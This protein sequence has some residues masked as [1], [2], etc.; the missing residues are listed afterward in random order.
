MVVT[1][2]LATAAGAAY[3]VIADSFLTLWV[4][5]EYVPSDA[6]T[7]LIVVM[8]L[9]FA[10]IRND[11][12]IID[13]TLE[14]KGKVLLGLLAAAVSIAIASVLVAVADMGIAGLAL[15][16]VARPR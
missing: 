5:A 2:L 12:S 15:G 16:F 6:A 7:L 8:T 1:W 9:Q 10:F 11:S 3:I 4:G 14:L 13:L